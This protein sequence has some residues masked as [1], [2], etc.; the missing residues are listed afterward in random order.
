MLVAVLAALALVALRVPWPEAAAPPQPALHATVAAPLR[1]GL[2][3]VETQLLESGSSPETEA[4]PLVTG[5]HLDAVV[6]D[7]RAPG[8]ELGALGEDDFVDV[9]PTASGDASV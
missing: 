5:L 3:R 4:A 8:P 2:E 1:R 9:T 6:V 7:R